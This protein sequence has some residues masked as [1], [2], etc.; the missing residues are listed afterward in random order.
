M[1]FLQVT[2]IDNNAEEITTISVKD[3]YDYMKNNHGRFFIRLHGF[4]VTYEVVNIKEDELLTHVFLRQGSTSHRPDGFYDRGDGTLGHNSSC[5]NI[6]S[7]A[8]W[9]LQETFEDGT[10]LYRGTGHEAYEKCFDIR[11]KN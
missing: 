4:Q 2:I 11:V 7:I 8:L 1:S 9:N 5:A 3:L 10:S 6:P